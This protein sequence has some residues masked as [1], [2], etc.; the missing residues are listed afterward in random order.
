MFVLNAPAE[1]HI[2]S[3]KKNNIEFELQRSNIFIAKN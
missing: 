3:K 1:Q 2:Y